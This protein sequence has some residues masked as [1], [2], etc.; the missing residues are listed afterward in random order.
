MPLLMFPRHFLSLLIKTYPILTFFSFKQTVWL[1]GNV[2]WCVQPTETNKTSLKP[3]TL[4]KLMFHHANSLPTSWLVAASLVFGGDFMWHVSFLFWLWLV[5]TLHSSQ[6][7]PLKALTSMCWALRRA[8]ERPSWPQTWL[9]QL[10]HSVLFYILVLPLWSPQVM[11]LYQ[12]QL[13][14]DKPSIRT[15]L[16]FPH[17]PW[18]ADCLH[19]FVIHDMV[20][21]VISTSDNS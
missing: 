8:R 1:S 16:F 10:I 12:V 11:L 15:S 5:Q 19:L 18:V 4:I 2:P 14:P 13:L 6:F 9:M 21:L 7:C 17:W 20:A 3:L